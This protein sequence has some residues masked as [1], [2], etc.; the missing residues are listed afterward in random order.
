MNRTKLNFNHRDSEAQ[1]KNKLKKS[2]W[3]LTLT[4]SLTLTLTLMG[5][6]ASDSEAISNYA[7]PWSSP[8]VIDSGPYNAYR[9]DI[10][11]DMNGNA[12]SVFE[13]KNGDVYRVFASRYANGKG[14][15]SAVP[16][17]EGI[18][19]G[20]RG[21][22][23]F[24]REGNAI[25]VFKQANRVYA[26]RYIYNKGWQGAIPIDNGGGPA[27]GQDIVFD[28]EGNAAAVF[29]AQD[30][31]EMGI[32]VN[33][34]NKGW[35]GAFRIDSGIGNAYF[36]NP[37][38][39]DKGNL[40][41]LYYKEESGG[42]EVYVSRVLPHPASPYKGEEIGRV[43][44]VRITDGNIVSKNEKWDEKKS[45]VR[46]GIKAVYNPNFLSE[47]KKRI[48]SGNYS[49]SRWETPSKLDSRFRDAYRPSLLSN[50][51]GELS[52]LFVKWDGEYLSAYTANYR[53]GKWGKPEE[54]DSGN[55]DVEHIRGA[56][57]LSGE[58]AVVWTQWVDGNLRIHARIKNSVSDSVSV[59]KN[60]PITHTYTH[61]DTFSNWGEAKIIDAGKKD[62]YNPSIIFTNSGEI[63][64]VWC[65]WEKTNVKSY[66]NIYRKGAGWSKAERLENKEGET[67]GVRV[68][69]GADGKVIAIFE[70]EQ[71][72]RFKIQDSRPT[73]RIFAV[74][75]I[76]NSQS[77]I[78]NRQSEENYTIRRL[79]SGDREDYYAE[80]SPD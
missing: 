13:Q 76:V 31:E 20:Y 60:N 71:D 22:V 7:S 35:S 45:E 69:S 53:N 15:E 57:N 6:I 61:T 48:Y 34:Y 2:L 10:A 66:T 32:Y 43:S 54:I 63:I 25:V 72:S 27:D 70:Q 44:T 36:P 4:L 58:I 28:N 33:L 9:T 1:R 56:V 29:E 3:I 79:T 49:Y 24:D 68:A 59:R 11:F 46:R 80:F 12:I 67:C 38:F 62:G 19:N 23:A 17:D 47:I 40:Y 77:S 18:D 65:Q 78:V 52:A 30:G 73:N 55:G 14:W 41:V 37:L 26:N 50:G 74:E 39:D 8:V 75:Y 16:I 51:K 64:A 42:L 5:V 21:Q